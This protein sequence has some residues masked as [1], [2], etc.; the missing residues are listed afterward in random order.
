M[1]TNIPARP[2]EEKE[3]KVQ[4]SRST[5]FD[6]SPQAVAPER[7]NRVIRLP[8]PE[9]D[10]ERIIENADVF[11]QHLD[12]LSDRHPELFPELFHQ[13]YRMKDI[14]HSLKLNMPI[15][16]IE[17][18]GDHIFYT[19][20]PS[21]IM[22]Y[23]TALVSDVDN[24]LFLR[25][26]NVPYWALAHVFGRNP[27]FWYRQEVGLGRFSLAQTTVKSS[28]NLPEHLVADEKHTKLKGGKV[29]IATTVGSGCVLGCELSE[30]AGNESLKGAYSV[31]KDEVKKVDGSYS[32]TTVNL[33]GWPATNNAWRELF[34]SVTIISCILHIYIKLRDCSKNKW[35]EAFNLVADKFW[36]CYNAPT[37]AVFSQRVRRLTEWAQTAN[38]PSFMRE[39]IEKMRRNVSKF[40]VAYKFPG[41]HRTSNMLDRL[42]QRMDC[43]LSATQYFHGTIQSANLA[44]RGWC[45]ILNFAPSNPTTVKKTPELTSPAER[46]N[47]SSYHRNWLQNLL[48]STSLVMRYQAPPP[49][50]L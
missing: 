9:N 15:R 50:P 47:S 1:R 26:F 33:D 22:P 25:K 4:S 14:R 40:S 28:Q 13:G 49:K 36:E 27:M 32:P 23:G 3:P 34:R 5:A 8:F 12:E 46:I 44:M 43:R 45:L 18:G 20:H 11:R 48:I 24:A 42:M 41:S 30:D 38:V 37:K 39:R 35:R 10:Y 17:T 19:I 2:K 21:F 6:N 31:F 29:Y 7:N 16:R